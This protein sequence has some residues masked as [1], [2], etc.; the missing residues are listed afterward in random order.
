MQQ[1]PENEKLRKTCHKS[2]S[3]V[4]K[5]KNLRVEQLLV[6]LNDIV[7]V[8]SADSTLPLVQHHSSS[9]D[10]GW[11]MSRADN[12]RACRVKQFARVN[13]S[14]FIVPLWH[15]GSTFT[16]FLKATVNIDNLPPKVKTTY[17]HSTF[18]QLF[19]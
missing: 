1:N 4:R 14:E 7:E 10:N 18:L 16:R 2:V 6:Y 17:L 19:F 9:P 5:N 13:V 8:T 12:H 15:A 3:S 11:E